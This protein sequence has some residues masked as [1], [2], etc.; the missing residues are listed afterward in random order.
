M[1]L[2]QPG[3]F[4]TNGQITVI[5]KSVHFVAEKVTCSQDYLRCKREVCSSLPSLPGGLQSQLSRSVSLYEAPSLCLCHSACCVGDY[6]VWCTCKSVVTK[7]IVTA[8]VI[9]IC[10]PLRLMCSIQSESLDV[11]IG[12]IGSLSI[13]F[14]QSPGGL[15]HWLA[16]HVVVFS[17][18]T[19]R[20]CF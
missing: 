2:A 6:C 15:M 10:F 18:W 5:F 20:K 11:S 9:R 4:I 16:I 3:A 8:L 7:L 17:G 13:F 19:C 14:L 1:A 12:G